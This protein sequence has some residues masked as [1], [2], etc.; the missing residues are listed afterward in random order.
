MDIFD[1]IRT[2]D[3]EVVNTAINDSQKVHHK[4]NRGGYTPLILATYLGQKRITKLILKTKM[5]I[6]AKDNSGNTALM[7]VCYKGYTEIAELLIEA[8]A[9][10]N[11]QNYNGATAL[12]YA[13][14]FNQSELVTLLLEHGA[15]PRIP[16]SRGLKPSDHAKNQGLYELADLI[17][18][19]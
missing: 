15:D 11:E 6:N 19:S 16:D 10:V 2:E 17:N 7:G 9:Q 4:R 1:A 13:A 12:T 5:D 8:G 18:N 3:A 14:T